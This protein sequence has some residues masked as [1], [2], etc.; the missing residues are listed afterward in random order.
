MEEILNCYNPIS[1]TITLSKGLTK[2][3]DGSSPFW[4]I[5]LQDK[6]NTL[7]SPTM[8][9]L[10][11]TTLSSALTHFFF[12]NSPKTPFQSLQFSPQD[13]MDQGHFVK[14]KKL[15]IYPSKDQTILFNKCIGASRYFYNKTV[16]IVNENG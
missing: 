15:K 4:D 8:K 14:T 3:E 16:Y 1:Q 11:V 6:Y 12:V 2:V 9:N 10:Q 5:S 7:W 13:T